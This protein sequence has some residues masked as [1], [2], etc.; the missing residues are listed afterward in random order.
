MVGT[1]HL[2]IM[3][4]VAALVT[5]GLF[6]VLGFKLFSGSDSDNAGSGR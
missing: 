2:R 4:A 3:I 6:V 5:V 1:S